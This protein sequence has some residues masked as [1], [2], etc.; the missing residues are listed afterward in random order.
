M[1]PITFL[2]SVFQP[3]DSRSLERSGV[4]R[5]P[6]AALELCAAGTS[7]AVVA[8]VLTQGRKAFVHSGW[9]PLLSLTCALPD[10]GSPWELRHSFARSGISALPNTD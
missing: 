3:H 5:G 7:R 2:A 4:L 6:A 1:S 10:M 8:R 9:D